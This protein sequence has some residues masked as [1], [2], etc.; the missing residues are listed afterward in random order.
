MGKEIQIFKYLLEKNDK[1]TLKVSGTS[2]FPVIKDGET[3]E[4][5]SCGNYMVGDILVYEYKNE[6]LIAH[7]LLKIQ[8]NHYFCKGDNSFRLEDI[9]PEQIIGKIEI[10]DVNN[11]PEFIEASYSISRLFRRCGYSH[12]DIQRLEEYIEYKEKYLR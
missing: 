7:R 1:C 11:T 2:M 8:N 4:V 5:I 3:V 9:S 6:G 10:C 12:E